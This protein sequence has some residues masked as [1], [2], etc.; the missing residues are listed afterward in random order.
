[1]RDVMCDRIHD[2]ISGSPAEVVLSLKAHLDFVK[3]PMPLLWSCEVVVLGCFLKS[4]LKRA[5]RVR[6]V[7]GGSS[8]VPSGA[9]EA[10]APWGCKAQ[11]SVDV[12]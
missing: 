11:H 1:M 3:N 8:V 2:M 10:P 5:V 12:R 4:A 9:G 6:G 7:T